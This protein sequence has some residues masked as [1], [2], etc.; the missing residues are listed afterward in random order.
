VISRCPCRCHRRPRAI[1]SISSTSCRA[2]SFDRVAH[3]PPA[4]ISPSLAEFDKAEH[5]DSPIRF[6]SLYSTNG[7]CEGTFARSR[8]IIK[9]PISDATRAVISAE[10]NAEYA[11]KGQSIEMR[12]IETEPK[13]LASHLL[14]DFTR[15]Y[16]LLLSSG[17][18]S[19]RA[20]DPISSPFSLHPCFSDEARAI[21]EERRNA[22]SV[23]ARPRVST[24]SI[25]I[26]ECTEA[27]RTDKFS[28]RSGLWSL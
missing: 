9:R 21:S 10:Y 6:N 20:T 7:R 22:S 25:K 3:L 19:A 11:R 14:I 18:I 15:D 24:E 1:A 26:Y 2:V 5:D 23:V 13:K 12:V 8:R 27:Y 4:L 28:A 16:P 17:V